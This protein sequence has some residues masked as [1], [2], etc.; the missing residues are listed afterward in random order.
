MR[1]PITLSFRAIGGLNDD[2][3]Y[4]FCLDNQDLTFERNAAGQIM[5]IPNAGGKWEIGMLRSR[6]S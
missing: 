5:L 2:A 1:H 3:F 6:F 4:C